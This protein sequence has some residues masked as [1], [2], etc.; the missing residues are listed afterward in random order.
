MTTSPPRTHLTRVHEGPAALAALPVLDELC[1]ATG[2][3]LSA[4]ALW[5]RAAADAAG[6]RAHPLL[7]CVQ[8]DGETVAA[9]PL[10]LR[11]AYGVH[12]V[13]LMSDGRADHARLPARDAAAAEALAQGIAGLLARRRPWRLHLEQLPVQDPVLTALGR[14]LPLRTAPGIGCPVMPLDHDASV[15]HQ[16]SQNGRRSWRNG[17][18]RLARD[19][20]A[21]HLSWLRGPQVLELLPAV[22]DL[23]RERD[24]ALG[25][26]S[27][28]DSQRGRAFH[29]AI[30]TQTA[31]A[32]Q[33]EALRLDIDGTLAAYVLVLRD[34]PVLHVWDGRVAPGYERYGLGWLSHVALLDH[35]HGDR[36]IERVDWMRGE[37]EN[38]QRTTSVVVPSVEVRA[39]S[40]RWLR[41]TDRAARWARARA[42]SAARKAVPAHRRHQARALLRR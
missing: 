41:G 11:R 2:A 18:N 33:L 5:C 16:L 32:G 28:L 25:R 22:Q 23:R 1:R 27:D 6:P 40:D 15:Q 7:V 24:H 39:E 20:R 19:G 31:S 9:A 42:L 36:S 30:A 3:P 17:R 8:S 38:K 12:E 21:T 34:G 37:Q 14:Q 29:Q 10:L 13:R 4:G 35:A 26:A